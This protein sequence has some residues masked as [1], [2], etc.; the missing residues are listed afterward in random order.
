MSM[1]YTK[2]KLILLSNAFLNEQKLQDQ[3]VSFAISF[4]TSTNGE[5]S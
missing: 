1:F 4:Q 3:I 2:K 5:F